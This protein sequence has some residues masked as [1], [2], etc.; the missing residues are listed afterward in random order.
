M[1]RPVSSRTLAVLAGLLF[2]GCAQTE[3][4]VP[5]MATAPVQKSVFESRSVP[6]IHS[7]VYRTVLDNGVTIV[8]IP[9]P[10]VPVVSFRIGILAGSAQDPLKQAGVASLTASLLNRGTETKDALSIFR[11]IDA[12]G[13]DLEAAT[14]RDLTTLSGKVLTS[15]L[16]PLFSLAADMVR[17]PIFKQDE[18]ARNLEQ[19]K[20]ERLEE[21]NHAGSV[22]RNLFYRTLFGS[23]PY[24]HPASGTMDSLS[25]LTRANV[26]DFYHSYYRP[27]RTTIT[28]AGD[29]T[30]KKALALVK[31]AFGDWTVTSPPPFPTLPLS[32]SPA[33]K[34]KTLLVDRPDLEQAMVM[35]GTYGLRRD[36]PRF[37][38]AL[39]MNQIL[40][41]STTSTLNHVVRQKNGLVYYIYSGFDAE[42]H[43]GPFFVVFQT[44]APNTPKV[45]ELTRKIL[46][47]TRDAP[48][49][50]KTVT[51]VQNNLLGQFPFRVDSD[52]RIAS[53]L[54]YIETYRLGLTYFTDYP[55]K[56]QAVT[57]DSVRKAAQTF[58]HPDSMVT[59]IV[60]PLKKTGVREG[61]KVPQ[62]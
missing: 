54:L 20:A 45:L 43:T 32:L 49:S 47:D 38:D 30:P 39:V 42:R 62:L 13:G 46:G 7:K 15:D 10:V 1:S 6:V 61:T 58:L 55:A 40:G 52:D 16:D 34:S 12:S 50:Q 36:D 4:A 21:R 35:M 44:H 25:A 23:G 56:V 19:A 8:V 5:P 2:A 18:F 17:H 48:V 29:I 53:L 14:G 37:Y 51:T 59:V 11:A 3:Q 24:G 57:P 31:A 22:A 9:R 41:G 60:G 28:F 27:D 33:A 26:V